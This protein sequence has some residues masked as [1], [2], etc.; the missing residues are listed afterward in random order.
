MAFDSARGVTVLFGGYDGSPY[1]D[2]WEWNGAVWLLRAA[3]GPS[4]RSDFAMSYDAR[5]GAT[6]LFGGANEVS[7]GSA[8][9]W[10]W[11]G[12]SWSLRAVGGPSSRSGHSMT[13]DTGR[14][15]TVLFGGN[16]DPDYFGD[17][18][19]M[20]ACY[21]N[22]DGSTAPP[23]LNANDFQCFLNRYAAGDPTANCDGSTSQPILNANDSQ[24][25]LNAYAAGCS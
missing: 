24:C 11:N 8:D 4:P 20:P 3:T 5:R 21:A 17:T 13:Y 14:G 25:F 9:T 16:S 7:V 23:I 22:C 6:V 1:G 2:T 18:W 12:A 15:T 10:E 19:E